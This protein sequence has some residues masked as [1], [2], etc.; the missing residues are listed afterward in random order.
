MPAPGSFLRPQTISPV[1]YGGRFRGYNQA[2]SQSHC[3]GGL[4]MAE[5]AAVFFAVV[6]VPALV[7][8]TGLALGLYQVF[9]A[10]P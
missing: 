8:G 2:V 9:T 5:V 10:E 7:I 6:V 4:P 3:P 1:V